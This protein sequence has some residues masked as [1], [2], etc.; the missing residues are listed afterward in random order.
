MFD[1]VVGNT[2]PTHNNSVKDTETPYINE[3]KSRRQTHFHSCEPFGLWEVLVF[4]HCQFAVTPRKRFGTMR[5]SHSSQ[6][7]HLNL[8]R[9]ISRLRVLGYVV[10]HIQAT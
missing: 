7:R 3:Y 2:I 4:K 10:E 6:L 9:V 8:S 5:M 1:Y